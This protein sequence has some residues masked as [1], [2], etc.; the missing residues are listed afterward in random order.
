MNKDEWLR[1]LLRQQAISVQNHISFDNLSSVSSF[2][3][4][5]GNPEQGGL[6]LN[7]FNARQSLHRTAEIKAM[8]DVPKFIEKSVQQGF[9]HF[10]NDAGGS[11][12][13]LDDD[14]VYQTL[15][16]HTL[17][18]YIK[19]SRHDESNLIKRSQTHPKPMYYQ[20][21][22]LKAQLTVYLAEN[23]LSYVAQINPNAFIN[24][25]FPRLLKHRTPKY[26]A[27]AKKYG[28]TINSEDLRDCKSAAAVLGLIEEAAIRCH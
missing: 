13:E 28:C 19:A 9:H 10:I 17:I 23:G 2:L 6:P 3:G 25:I 20:A 7:E 11:L 22:F 5:I 18:L 4:K 27:I 24:W 21:G 15:A 26:Q 14:K 8:L 1:E 16:K 12:C